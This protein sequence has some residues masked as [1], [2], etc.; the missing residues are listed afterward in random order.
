MSKRVTIETIA[1]ACNTSIGTV[2]RAISN[3]K[4]ISKDTK[5]MIL[6]KAKELGYHTNRKEFLVDDSDVIN[7]AFIDYCSKSP[8]HEML[9][10]G[11]LQ[12]ADELKIYR[13]RV[14][15]FD[16]L[17]F[18]NDEEQELLEKINADLFNGIAINTLDEGTSF[19]TSKIKKN[20]KTI[21]ASN[22]EFNSLA[23]NFK[24]GSDG[25][26]CGCIAGGLAGEFSKSDDSVA[27]MSSFISKYVFVERFSGFCRIVK[28]DYSQ[29]KLVPFI[30]NYQ[31]VEEAQKEVET[32]LETGDFN[33]LHCTD[34]NGT[35]G[36][37]RALRQK[38]TKDLKLIGYDVCEE[39]SKALKE[40]FCTA[41]IYHDV[42]QYGYKAVKL[43]A[44]RII[45]GCEFRPEECK[46]YPQI[47]TK[48]NIDNFLACSL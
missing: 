17:S 22:I 13:V 47:I 28:N 16:A 1:K 15:Y 24:F 27:V 43:L 5:A 41:L 32:I 18:D 8:S 3:R 34:F 35:I 42:R 6:A 39:S 38:N 12:A 45:E 26:S 14:V 20:I 37:I 44:K 4:G 25:D 40:G 9:K 46:I 48:Y 7:I 2:D 10:E 30:C 29:I 36:A 19:L 31:T 11:V 21:I 23:L 33:V